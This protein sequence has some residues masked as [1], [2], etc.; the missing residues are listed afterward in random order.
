MKE[1]FLGIQ[2]FF[3]NLAFA[4]MNALR[5]MELENWWGANIFNWIFML[6]LIVA[7]VY[8][9]QQLKKFNENKDENRSVVSHSFLAEKLQ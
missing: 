8:W 6:I 9:M 4:P 5:S 7:L 1:L 3:E 2:S